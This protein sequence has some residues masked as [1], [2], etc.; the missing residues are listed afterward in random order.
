MSLNPN[1]WEHGAPT[2]DKPW[3]R[4]SYKDNGKAD[5]FIRILCGLAN[6]N[7]L[8]LKTS[9]C[10]FRGEDSLDYELVPKLCR[11]M[12]GNMSPEDKL[13][14]E[15]DSIDYF[16]ERAGHYLPASQLPK[17]DWDITS[18]LALMQHFGAATRLL[19]WT[20]S[21]YVAIYFA[22]HSK[23]DEPGSVWII[24]NEALTK[25][26][27]SYDYGFGE[28]DELEKKIFTDKEAFVNFGIK[29]AQ[30]IIDVVDSACK[31]KRISAQ[32]GVF[33]ICHQQGVNHGQLI[34][35][36]LMNAYPLTEN[37][38]KEVFN[39]QLWRFE[40]SIRLKK[41]LRQHLSTLGMSAVTLFPGLDGLGRAVTEMLTA[42]TEAWTPTNPG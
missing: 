14:Y 5:N 2:P 26:T 39:A 19:D 42:Y 25:S 40:I 21:V 28:N 10:F 18:W 32:H 16:R 20:A 15:F 35:K 38:T 33:T 29:S 23:T 12:N 27:P 41:H 6:L 34:G 13:R 36:Q 7:A 1:E 30:P 17:N 8:K 31:T 37:L 4:F 11:I 9:G 22:V 24:N 3:V